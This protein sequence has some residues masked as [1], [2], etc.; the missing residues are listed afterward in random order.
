MSAIAYINGTYVRKLNR[1]AYACRIIIGKE[2][3]QISG[4]SDEESL[5]VMNSIGSKILAAEMAIKEAIKKG[6]KELSIINNLNFVEDLTL[7]YCNPQQEGT[8][9]YVNYINSIS[10]QIKIDVRRPLSKEEN[11]MLQKLVY[12][13]RDALNN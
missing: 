11:L 9:N 12:I 2:I 1:C 10:D 5:T 3:H 13:A 7:G 6:V 8:I 4:K